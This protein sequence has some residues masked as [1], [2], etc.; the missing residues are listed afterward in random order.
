VAHPQTS[1]F[2]YII[3]GAGSAGCVLAARLSEDA[4][5]RVLLLEAGGWDRDPFIHI[6]LG[7]GKLFHERRHDWSY[8]SAPEHGLNGRALPFIRGKVIGGS[9]S[10]NA[11]AYVRGHRDDYD[12]WARAGLSG[13]GY[14]S[15]LAYFKRQESW[16]GGA[17]AYRGGSG[18]LHTRETGYRD[19]LDDAFVAAGVQAGFT[20]TPDYNGAVQEGFGRLQQ[21]IQHGR[22]SSSASAY[23]RPALRR[24]GLVVQVGAHA[25]RIIFQGSR[26]TE[27]E[28]LQRGQTRRAQATGEIILAGGVFNTPQLL[29]LSGIGEAACL[30]QHGIAPLLDLPG[31]GANLQEHCAAMFLG[32]RRQPG[33]FHH[34]M[35]AD[36]IAGSLA[37]AYLFGS[38]FAADV[39][40]GSFAFLKSDPSEPIPDIQL[41]LN[42][43]PMDAAPYLH[44]R[45]GSFTDGFNCMV[46]LLRPQSRGSVT[47]RSADPLAAPVIRPNLLATEADLAVLKRGLRIVR[48]LA[49]RTPLQAFIGQEIVAP[50]TAGMTDAALEAHVRAFAVTVNHPLGT[51]RMGA[52]RDPGAVLDDRLRVRGAQGLRVVDASA[53][54]DTV[55]G[56]INAAVIMIAE[57]AADLIKAAAEP[58]ATD[59]RLAA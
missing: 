13:W 57:R 43:S 48:D 30:R 23:L 25:T 34:A 49:G 26:A 50:G 10:I 54:P 21:T 27:V 7:F 46:A 47:L 55:G 36:R 3:V 41:I 53:M 35:R 11:M 14:E 18:P 38:G 1:S 16:A 20:T 37:R 8:D 31:V 12:R 32:L 28:Y 40:A 24:P 33:P 39:P 42:L 9:S 5:A 2:D 19:P 6:P 44:P 59:T 15:V 17:S 52:E 58:A 4:S 51:C 45:L 22:R 56:N 29:M